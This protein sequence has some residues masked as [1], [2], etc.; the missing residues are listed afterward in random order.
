MATYAAVIAKTLFP[1]SGHS[2]VCAHSA[3]NADRE[4]PMFRTIRGFIACVVGVALLGACGSGG[5][6]GPA[7]A[8]AP[9]TSTTAA[10]TPA[11]AGYRVTVDPAQF[12]S[13][14]THPYLVL[15][16]KPG[17][18]KIL[19]GTRDGKPHRAEVVVTDR[20][21]KVMGVDCIVVG[22]TVTSNGA[23][24]EKTEDWYAQ[25]RAGNVWYFGENTAEYVNG[26]VTS[27]HGTWEAG[28][29]GA[30]PGVILHAAPKVGE[31]YYQ[32]YRPGEAEDRAK[33][34]SLDATVTVPAGTYTGVITTEDSDP[35]NPDKTDKKWY[36]KD[37]GVVHTIRIK[38]GHQEDMSLVKVLSS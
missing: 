33:V 6:K 21:R 1:F 19:E 18:T 30:Q 16:M 4:G 7:A 12:S 5:G 27:T 37:I 11:T 26:V 17:T 20:T 10:P 2:G 8:T 36:A 15:A 14:I 38:S 24:V 3:A 25:D 32:E 31:E 35:L 13:A 28:V 23:L 34:L 22:D 9:P 29:D